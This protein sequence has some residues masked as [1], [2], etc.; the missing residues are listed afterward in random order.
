M[1]IPCILSVFLIDS[2]YIRL[3][4]GVMVTIAFLFYCHDMKKK[5]DSCLAEI[6]FNEWDK[7]LMNVFTIT[8]TYYNLEDECLICLENFLDSKDSPRQIKC[9]C[10][11]TVYHESC[12]TQWFEKNCS[13]PVCRKALNEKIHYL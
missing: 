3:L 11:K 5:I 4:I 9:D 2:K 1:I 6:R 8:P 7:N 13:C 12:L 10:T